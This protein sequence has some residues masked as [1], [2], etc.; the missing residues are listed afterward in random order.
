MRHLQG[1]PSASTT[2]VPSIPGTARQTLARRPPR[3]PC[4]ARHSP[5]PHT[6]PHHTRQAQHSLSL[7]R[8]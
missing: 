4:P 5:P 1:R 8:G 2:P 3:P 6:T 7:P